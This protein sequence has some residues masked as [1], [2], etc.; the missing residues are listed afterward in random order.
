MMIYHVQF[1]CGDYYCDGMHTVGIFDEKTLAE[2]AISEYREKVAE[3]FSESYARSY[4]ASCSFK[5][6]ERELNTVESY[7]E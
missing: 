2:K 4:L 1:E 5:V 7:G 6:I 3:G